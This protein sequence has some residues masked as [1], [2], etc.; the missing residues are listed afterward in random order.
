MTSRYVRFIVLSSVDEA[1]KI[2]EEKGVNPLYSEE[3]SGGRGEIYGYL[4]E[5]LIEE[6]FP[7]DW[8]EAELPPIDWTAQW[9]AHSHGYKDGLI[10]IPIEGYGEVTLRPGPGFGDLSHPS[11]RLVMQLMPIYVK[12]RCVVDVGCGSGI[13]SLCAAAYGAKQVFGIDI[14]AESLQHSLKN[15]ELNQMDTVS[16]LF[17]D[18]L[19]FLPESPV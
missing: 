2:L 8:E 1:W 16:F 13:L 15:K 17:P 18:E 9:D 19:M 10:K 14:S 3:R 4:P 11:T 6:V 7:F 5:T 12:N